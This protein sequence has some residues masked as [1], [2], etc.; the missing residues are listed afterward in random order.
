MTYKDSQPRVPKG[1]PGGGRWVKEVFDTYD[2]TVDSV[3]RQV[4]AALDDG[5]YGYYGLRVEDVSTPGEVGDGL[6]SSRVWVDGVP[7]D[8]ELD[9]TS[10]IGLSK[11]SNGDPDR[12]EIDKAMKML[13]LSDDQGLRSGYVGKVVYVVGGTARQYGEDP[14][15]HILRNA[16]IVAVYTRDGDIFSPLKRRL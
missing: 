15:E 5:D 3:F 4:E 7:T 10:V 1:Q 16:E 12:S 14:G 6:A 11:A 2:E 13:G 8:E 9:G